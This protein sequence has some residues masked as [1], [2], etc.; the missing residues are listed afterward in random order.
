[1]LPF[2]QLLCIDTG[3]FL[4]FRRKHIREIPEDQ[5]IRNRKIRK[6]PHIGHFASA[7]I[8]CDP[9]KI[10][11]GINTVIHQDVAGNLFPF[12]L[13]VIPIDFFQIHAGEIGHPVMIHR[14]ISSPP[15]ASFLK[16]FR[17]LRILL[18]EP[19]AAVFKA[20]NPPPLTCPRS[21]GAKGKIIAALRIG[22]MPSAV[23]C[24][25]GR[26][27]TGSLFQLPRLI[28]APHIPFGERIFSLSFQRLILFLQLLP[29]MDF[30]RPFLPH[31]LAEFIHQ[32]F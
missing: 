16:K 19:F 13:P 14:H 21:A 6:L 8:H 18:R 2:L 32:L 17:I 1:M 24:F 29:G 3:F 10:P 9:R 5:R 27:K 7:V 31:P 15:P 30:S 25:A 11:L 26:E 4:I 12:F 20:V 22:K 28:T 23:R